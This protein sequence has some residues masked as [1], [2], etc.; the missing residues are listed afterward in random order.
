MAGTQAVFYRDVN[1]GEPVD[2]F[3]DALPA[4]RAAKIDEYIEQHLNARPPNEPPPEYPV[5]SQIDGELRE[6]R[7][8]FAN[9]RY[10]ILYQRSDNLI[11]LLHAI[12]KDTGAVATSDIQL[13]K[14]RMADFQDRMGASRRRPPRAAGHDAPPPRRPRP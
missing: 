12:E 14:R 3:I 6:L 13:A 8:R 4:K 7:V 5:S 10:R 1:G 11:V 2:E 9:T